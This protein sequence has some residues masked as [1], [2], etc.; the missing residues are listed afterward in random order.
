LDEAAARKA[1]ADAVAE[2]GVPAADPLRGPGLDAL[3]D[4]CLAS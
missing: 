3:V 2:L 4:A 1:L